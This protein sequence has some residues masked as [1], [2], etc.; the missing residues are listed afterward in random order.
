[1]ASA[2]LPIH[3]ANPPQTIDM[4]CK[5]RPLYLFAM[6]AQSAWSCGV[7]ALSVAKQIK[8]VL[9]FTNAFNNHSGQIF[10]RSTQL[11]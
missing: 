6:F 7:F 4:P 11:F 2:W 10:L 3:I 8:T 1:M 9:F 5:P